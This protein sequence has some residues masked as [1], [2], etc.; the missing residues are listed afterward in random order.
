MKRMITSSILALGASGM[1]LLAQSQPPS[2]Q[3]PKKTPTSQTTDTQMATKV[4]QAIMQDQTLGSAAHN[5]KVTSQNG[6][7][8]LRGKVS[9]ADEKD[10]I[11]AKAK[12]VAGDTNVKD[13]LT[14]AKSK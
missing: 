8:V 14:V 3:P 4:R 1:M 7:V 13:E 11:L 5:V 6:M 12:Q 9:T 2:S 10:A